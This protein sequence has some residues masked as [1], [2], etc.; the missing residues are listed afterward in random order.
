MKNINKKTITAFAL[1]AIITSGVGIMTVSF[2]SD[3]KQN[4]EENKECRC[5]TMMNRK[6]GRPEM[7]NEN[8][9]KTVT[10]KITAIENNTIT[11]ETI[12]MFKGFEK[13]NKE[14]TEETQEEKTFETISYTI[15]ISN[16]KIK[17]MNFNVED[18]KMKEE[19]LSISDIAVGNYI[20]VKG[21]IAENNIVA[22]EIKLD[23]QRE[24]KEGEE[25]HKEFGF[26]KNFF[27]MPR[28]KMHQK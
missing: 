17:K 22:E 26:D 7:E 2:A 5:P 21:K 18:K 27:G 9:G 3:A 12:K 25:E 15:D 28:F 16:S 13:F 11:I 23:E 4:N 19:E 20:T 10:G 24:I 14:N 1:G 8:F 6:S